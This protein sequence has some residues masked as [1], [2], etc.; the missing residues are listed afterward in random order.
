MKI[1]EDKNEA[2]KKNLKALKR[3]LLDKEKAYFFEATHESMREKKNPAKVKRMRKE[4]AFLNT[5]IREKVVEE[6]K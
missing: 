1:V 6:I 4:I 3:E 5:I 2:K